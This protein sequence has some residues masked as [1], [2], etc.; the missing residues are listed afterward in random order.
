MRSFDGR[1]RRLGLGLDAPQS[2]V[3]CAALS[4]SFAWGEVPFDDPGYKARAIQVYG[5]DG[6]AQREMFIADRISPYVEK[7]LVDGQWRGPSLY[8]TIGTEDSLRPSNLV[9]RGRLEEKKIPFVYAENPCKHEW[10]YWD[11]HLR[12]ALA[13]L[14]LHLSAPEK[15]T[16]K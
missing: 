3:A 8:F 6:P 10:K 9:L 5:G 12:D 4:G 2:F 11:T 1:L 13:F 7:N 16:E 14:M 15:E